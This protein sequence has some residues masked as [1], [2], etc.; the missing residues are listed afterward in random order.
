VT[1]RASTP[2]WQRWLR[3]QAM[4]RAAESGT[5]EQSSGGDAASRRNVVTKGDDCCG[6]SDRGLVRP[7]NEDA[8]FVAPEQGLFV[9]SDGLGGHAAGEVA[10]AIAVES[11]RASI[12]ADKEQYDP[13]ALLDRAFAAAN[14]AVNEHTS[15]HPECAGMGATLIVAL[16]RGDELFLAHVG[17]VRA[18]HFHENNL[19]RVTQDHTAVGRLLQAGL[20]DEDAARHHPARN[21]VHQA[22]GGVN[23]LTPEYARVSLAAGDT[24]LLCS[25]GLW[26]EV[27]HGEIAAVL[28]ETKPAL[29]LATRLVDKAIIAGGNDNITAVVYRHSKHTE[30]QA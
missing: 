15:K 4:P 14:I 20:I 23:T 7:G 27:S 13:A 3:R 21:Q 26:D 10:S 24:L 8:F 6:I 29:H 11:I 19:I 1:R 22:I 18:Y 28:A 2:I 5:S 25:D 12:D 30:A 9:V 16:I 17:D